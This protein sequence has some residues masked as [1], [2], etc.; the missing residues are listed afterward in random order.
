MA[1]S[2]IYNHTVNRFNE[3]LN[4]EADVYKLLLLNS[5]ATF[6][7]THTTLTEVD[8]A[9]AYEVSGNGWPSGGFTLQNIVT[10]IDATDGGIFSADNVAQAISGGTL[11]PYNNAVV[12][13]SSDSGSPPVM[14]IAIGAAVTIPDGVS[15]GVNMPDG[16]I[17]WTVT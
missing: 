12:V 17:K 9:G 4:G 6:N 10:A 8:N 3:G 2:S 16:M 15:A 5:S 11:G 7:A 1:T 14:F 13:N